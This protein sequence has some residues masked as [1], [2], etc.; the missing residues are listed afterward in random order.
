MLLR[1]PDHES[2]ITSCSLTIAYKICSRRRCRETRNEKR[3]NPSPESRVP[4]VCTGRID[5]LQFFYGQATKG[6]RWMPRQREAMKDVVSCEKLRGAANRLRSG[7]IRM[8][9]PGRGHARSLHGKS[10]AMQGERGELK[11]LSTFRRR[12]Q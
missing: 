10:I 3:G 8:G 11:H 6:V 12:K 9:Q 7:D 1:I 5:C 2:R 4:A